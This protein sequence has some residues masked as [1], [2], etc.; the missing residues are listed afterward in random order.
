M[1]TLKEVLIPKN[2]WV[3]IYAGT[4]ITVG[5][6]LNIQNLDNC[7]LKVTESLVIPDE[8]MYGYKTLKGNDTLATTEKPVGVW[9]WSSKDTSVSVEEYIPLSGIP[10]DAF[11]GM[12]A[13]NV[14][15]YIES[16]IKLG[17]QHEGST[18][19][20]GVAGNT[21]NNT[22]FLTGDSPVVLKSRN[23]SFTGVG[24]TAFIYEGST[25][26]GGTS[27]PYEN[28]NAINPVAGLST[29][30]VGANIDVQGTL[31]F[32]PDNLIGP[33]SAQSKGS[34]GKDVGQE[35]ILKPN[36]AY[37]LR[38]KSLDS[39]PQNIASIISWYEGGLDLPI[40]YP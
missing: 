32:A 20:L 3:N 9:V 34:I 29:I 12:R 19:L 25:Y 23:I 36:T 24:V 31:I 7:L 35:K 27:A 30:I 11:I 6:R 2:T 4:G 13:L 1:S 16:N 14:Q 39:Q 10:S 38:L 21:S 17:V 33:D 8:S 28:P 26:T 5:K 22:I 15:G 37:Q 40:Q 18:L